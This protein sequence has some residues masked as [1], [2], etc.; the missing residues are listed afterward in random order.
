[1]ALISRGTHRQMTWVTTR[2]RAQSGDSGFEYGLRSCS[3]PAGDLEHVVA[4]RIVVRHD[5]GTAMCCDPVGGGQYQ[6]ACCGA[7]DVFAVFGEAGMTADGQPDNRTAR[8]FVADD[9]RGLVTRA[10]FS[11]SGVR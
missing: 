1:M 8:P 9:E 10:R 3:A 2:D 6:G 11:Q 7:H 5:A 4:V